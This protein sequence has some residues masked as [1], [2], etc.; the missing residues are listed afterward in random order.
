MRKLTEK[1]RGMVA[2]GVLEEI[3]EG[4]RRAY[5]A[6]RLDPTLAGMGFRMGAEREEFLEAL[7]VLG[8]DVYVD[9]I[10]RPPR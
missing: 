3:V 6:N 9:P 7:M 10:P 4:L 1:Q 8:F 5:A 2:L